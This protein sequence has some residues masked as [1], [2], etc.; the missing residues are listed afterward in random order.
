MFSDV[1]DAIFSLK[2]RFLFSSQIEMHLKMIHDV[3]VFDQI[4][5]F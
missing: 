1:L 2:I 5:M 4:S 3:P